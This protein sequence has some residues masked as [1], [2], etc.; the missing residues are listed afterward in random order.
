[1]DE[2]VVSPAVDSAWEPPAVVEAST[3]GGRAGR[4]ALGALRDFG[5]HLV[6][7][8]AVVALAL[9]SGGYIF[10]LAFPIVLV[11]LAAAAVW[12]WFAPPPAL[13]RLSLAALVCLA[14]FVGW[15]GLSV[16]WSI[17]PD[18]TWLAFDFAALY[19]VVVVVCA[20]ASARRWNLRLVAYGFAFGMVP[21]AAWALLGKVLPDVATHAHEYAR[22][23]APVGYWNV[24]A[25]LMVMGAL[26]ALEGASRRTMP[27]ALRVVLAVVLGLFLL[28]LVFTFSR[29]GSLA[30]VVG[31]VAYFA[32]TNE[33]L[34]GAASLAAAAL[35]AAAALFR[36]RDLDTLFNATT[37]DRLRT[38]Q[39]HQFGRSVVLALAV[40]AVLE[41]A[42]ALVHRRLHA[43]RLVTAVAGA[44]VLAVAVLAVT[45]ASWAYVRHA[46]GAHAFAHTLSQQ[47]RGNDVS[48]EGNGNSIERVLSTSSNGRIPMWR[49]GVRA[50]RYVPWTG[51]GAGTFRFVNYRFRDSHLLVKHAHNQWV[52]V[53]TE[54]GIPGLVL[55]VAGIGLLLAAG[56]R[57]GAGRDGDRGA[58]AVLQ[59][60][61]LVFVLHMSVDWDWDMSS[62]TLAFLLF[63]GTAAAYVAGRR[64]EKAAGAAASEGGTGDEGEAARGWGRAAATRRRAALAPRLAATGLLVVVAASW[65]V[66]WLADRAYSSALTAASDDKLTQAAAD[67]RRAH[68]LDPLAADP[69]LALSLIEQQQGQVS[70]ARATI[71]RAVRL[72][73]LNYLTYY[74]LGLLQLNSLGDP[75]GAAASFRHALGLNPF[76]DLSRYELGLA[77]AAAGTARPR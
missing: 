59:A 13:G 55:F 27:V 6:I 3:R 19:L 75:R 9:R 73:P 37:D 49:E 68:R 70:Q 46:G 52:N 28:A 30:A 12:V 10:T 69:L 32:L 56:L 15:T 39:G 38:L 31:L 72:Q 20:S 47:L 29:G 50:Y 2:P 40:T 65:T 54:L 76:D 63:A 26:A 66:P 61:C 48:I 14:L 4:R 1:M 42:I 60:G 57:P 24:L 36:A 43:G 18:L 11:L 34:T 33:R 74:Q 77:R 64:R 35:P 62:A 7:L 17:G 67:A 51:T 44:I 71:E 45:G 16:A 5:P 23:S 8:G 25:L 53:L 22:L 21:V 41:L 58:L